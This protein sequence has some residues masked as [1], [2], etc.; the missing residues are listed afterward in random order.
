MRFGGATI[1]ADIDKSDGAYNPDLDRT[2]KSAFLIFDVTDPEIKPTLLGEITMPEMGFSTSY[3]TMVIMK[4]GDHDGSFENYNN[5]IPHDGENRWFLAFGSGPADAAGDPD[6]AVLYTAASSQ[7]AKFYLL[8]LVKLVSH[9]ELWSLTD[10]TIGTTTE[11]GVLTAGLHWYSELDS[12]SF[13][14]DPITVDFDLD[15]N[16]DVLYYGT[17][18]TDGSDWGGNMRRIVID[19]LNDVDEDQDPRNWEPDSML[20]NTEQ[21]IVAGATVGLDDDGRHW[22]YF[23][24]GRYFVTADTIDLSQQSYYGIKEPLYSGTDDKSWATVTNLIDT[25]NYMVFTDG[26]VGMG[27][28]GLTSS[29]WND[30]IS[31]QD[32]ADGWKIDFLNDSGSQEGER[33]LGQASLLGGT[34]AFTSYIP[35]ND[36]CSAGG[37]SFLWAV[38]YKTG[39]AYFDPIIG[40]TSI[41]YLGDT[42][43]L[44]TIKVS[45]GEGLATSPNIHVGSEDGSSAFVQTSTGVI[46]IVEQQNPEDIKSGIQSWK[47]SE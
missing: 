17:V 6:P 13:V 43:Q 2:M 7:T 38:Y 20:F 26:T 39:T 18:N 45:L 34:L 44:S 4:D 1:V 35:S 40:S 36:I 21:P 37:E 42:K 28:D 24:T 5:I 27:S 3:P 16:A 10:E 14:S 25:T 32:T 46:E 8:D 23:G 11:H 29:T 9:N 31:E 41:T 12:N 30:L 19:D 33:N 47:E 15:F 22:V